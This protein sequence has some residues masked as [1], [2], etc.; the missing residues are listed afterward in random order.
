MVRDALPL[1][2]PWAHHRAGTARRHCWREQDINGAGVT[3]NT[4]RGQSPASASRTG[5]H[6]PADSA[7]SVA[8]QAT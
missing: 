7:E 5:P 1:G 6:C 4:R 2:V 3:T 8:H